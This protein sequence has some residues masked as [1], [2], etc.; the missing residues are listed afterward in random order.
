MIT[1]FLVGVLIASQTPVT[2]ADTSHKKVI[3]LFED[4]INYSL[5]ERVKGIIHFQYDSIP[6][7]SMSVSSEQLPILQGDPSVISVQEDQSVQLESQITN[8]GNISIKSEESRKKGYT[9]KDVK[10]AIIDTGVDTD[11][12]DLEITDGKCFLASCPNSFH[13]D[14]G[15]GT[16]VAGIIGAQNNSIGVV[17]VVPD[18][19]IYALKVLDHEGIGDTST[20]IAGI[21]WA[22]KHDI[23]IINLSLST[24]ESDFALKAILN[25]AYNEGIL[26]VS[27][28][29]NSGTELGKENTVEYPAKYDS[30]IAVAALNSASKRISTSATGAEIEVAAPGENI[31][32]TFPRELDGD[33]QKDGYSWLTGTSMAAPFVVGILAQYKQQYPNKTNIEL[34][35]MLTDHALDL[36]NPGRDT[37]YGYGIVQANTND[38]APELQVQ[39]TSVNN[40]DVNFSLAS[41]PASVHSYSVYRDGKKIAENQTNLEF[42]DYILKGNYSYQFSTVSADGLESELTSPIAV[43]VLFPY[44]KDLTNYLWYTPELVYLS[45]QAIITGFED[46]TMRPDRLVTRAEAVA[47]IGRAVGLDGTVRNSVFPD[48]APTSFSS[49]YIQSAYENNILKG[50]PDG[51]FHPNQAVTRAEMAILLAK[52]YEL[53]ETSELTFTDVNENVTG[54]EAINMV[55]AAKITIGYPDGTFKP[56]GFMKRS[57]FG[58]F[59]A[60]A[61]NEKFR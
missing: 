32:S 23:D 56:F 38:N 22:I 60:R 42:H 55:A 37:W 9:G 58:V 7:V 8:W 31:F 16:H 4:T 49:G 26:I 34:R 17:G 27:A 40:G 18:A 50:F 3:I 15:H 2:A 51:T 10:I 45:S 33:G 21:D 43:E 48:V 47:M 13:D 25:K 59:I 53:T 30:V 46:D 6:A 28:A 35:K 5:I 19:T 20:V 1:I 52:A 11:H 24:T 14:N 39:A 61:E 57:E 36:G 54:F 41:L 12:P 29:G 44:Y